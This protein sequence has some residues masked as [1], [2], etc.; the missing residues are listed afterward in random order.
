[1]ECPNALPHLRCEL[2]MAPPPTPSRKYAAELS[3]F[4]VRTRRRTRLGC[5]G[6][7]LRYAL[8]DNAIYQ[9]RIAIGLHLCSRVMQDDMAAFA[10]SFCILLKCSGFFD[11]FIPSSSVK[12]RQRSRRLL[13]LP[14]SWFDLYNHNSMRKFG[15]IFSAVTPI[16]GIPF[17]SFERPYFLDS[18]QSSLYSNGEYVSQCYCLYRKLSVH[19]ALLPVKLPERSI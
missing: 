15:N 9:R 5:S 7:L 18:V 14:L 12:R 6:A 17:Q 1:M 3:V 19:V 10:V 8:Q 11:S 4:V 2:C 13:I 16:S